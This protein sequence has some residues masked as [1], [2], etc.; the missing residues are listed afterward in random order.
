MISAGYIFEAVSDALRDDTDEMMDWIK[1]SCQMAYYEIWGMLP[2]DAGRRKV[3]VTLSATA[4]VLLPAD[5]VNIEAVW[6]P[7]T[8]AEYTPGAPWGA[9]I[10]P[11][12][13]FLNSTFDSLAVLD[14]VSVSNTATVWTGGA[15]NAAYIGEYIRF[16]KNPGIYKITAANTFTPR[17]YGPHLDSVSGIVRPAGAKSMACMDE[18]GDQVSGAHDVYY[19]AYPPPLYDESQDILLPASRPLEL[20]TLIRMIGGKDRRDTVAQ[21]YQDEYPRALS[22]MKAMNPR[23]ISPRE[24]TNR[25]G[26]SMFDMRH[27]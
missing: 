10:R 11:T 4:G 20:L 18:N 26:G 12:W 3:S 16:G 5:I 8:G 1:R 19:W 22:D 13:F 7:T 6:N 24:P 25:T 15:W 23:F 9:A 21:K 2:W 14:Q 17:Y 27:R